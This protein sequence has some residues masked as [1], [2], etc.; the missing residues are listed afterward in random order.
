MKKTNMV[1]IVVCSLAQL[2]IIPGNF[3]AEHG[4]MAG[5]KIT[6]VRY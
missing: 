3:A 4:V 6:L 2:S 5:T 1:L